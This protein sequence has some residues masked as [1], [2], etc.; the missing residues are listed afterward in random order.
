MWKTNSEPNESQSP[1]DTTP[2]GEGQATLG[3]SITIKGEV[4]G[5][6]SLYIDGH[7]EGSIDLPGHRVTIGR[8]GVVLANINA[9]EIL[10]LGKVGGTVTASD[11]FDIR[12]DGSIVGDIVASRVSIEDGAYFKGTIDI[13]KPGHNDGRS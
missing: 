10:I 6:E 13:R 9:R 4:S 11:R 12:R 1:A 7:V 2:S 3:K 5:S 8:N